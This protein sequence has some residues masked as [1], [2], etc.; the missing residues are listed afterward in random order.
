[1]LMYP[2][3]WGRTDQPTRSCSASSAVSPCLVTWQ[4]KKKERKRTRTQCTELQGRSW[5]CA[6]FHVRLFSMGH[7]EN[8]THTIVWLIQE[9]LS[10]T[11]FTSAFLMTV[12]RFN[13]KKVTPFLSTIDM[14]VM[15][16]TFYAWLIIASFRLPVMHTVTQLVQKI[17][18]LCI[19]FLFCFLL[20]CMN[21]SWWG[22][23]VIAVALA[24]LK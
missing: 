2:Q 19:F 17:F 18:M 23:L 13:N 24:S 8:M 22:H 1:M 11:L 15:Q 14:R 16:A 4:D 10:Y 12:I 5:V 21:V 9:L 3:S 20:Y 6:F 7:W